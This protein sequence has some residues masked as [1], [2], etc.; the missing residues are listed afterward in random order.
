MKR[1]ESGPPGYGARRY[2]SLV[3]LPILGTSLEIVALIVVAWLW[4]FD[5]YI[6]NHTANS[7]SNIP[8]GIFT[9]MVTPDTDTFAYLFAKNPSWWSTLFLGLVVMGV[10]VYVWLLLNYSKDE[11]QLRTRARLYFILFF[12]PSIVFSVLQLIF[13]FG[14]PSIGPSGVQYSQIGIIAGFSL[15]NG[16]PL[17]RG[18]VRAYFRKSLLYSLISLVNLILGL[19]I[20]LYSIF[21]PVTFFSVLG[22]GGLKVD[23][24]THIFTYATSI[25][26]LVIWGLW[27]CAPVA[28][29]AFGQRRKTASK[30]SDPGQIIRSYGEGDTYGEDRFAEQVQE[31]HHVSLANHGESLEESATYPHA[32]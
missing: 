3:K 8:W 27:T 30:S 31:D 4:Q 6:F 11:G 18:G 21:D 29:P 15:V 2:L 9:S 7:Y 23:Y 1:R 19:V 22:L 5:N 10:F 25:V 12:V 20:V 16:F 28:D 32:D 14:L 13:N 26:V 24:Y 17:F